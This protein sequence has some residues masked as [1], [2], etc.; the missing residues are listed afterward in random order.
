[1]AKLLR[2]D[3]EDW[4]KEIVMIEEFYAKFGDKIP[5]ELNDCLAELKNKLGV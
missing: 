1:M 4:K 5:K 2:V 3:K